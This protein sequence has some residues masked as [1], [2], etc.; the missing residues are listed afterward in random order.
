M[1]LKETTSN[2]EWTLT[3]ASASILTCLFGAT[4]Q[5]GRGEERRI[6]FDGDYDIFCLKRTMTMSVL[7]P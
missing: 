3:Y 4:E 6:S 7:C 2:V 1:E 5:H